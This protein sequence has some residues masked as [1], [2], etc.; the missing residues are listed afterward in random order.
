VREDFDF[1]D[2]GIARCRTG[3]GCCVAAQAQ[4]DQVLA[5]VISAFGMLLEIMNDD[6]L[7]IVEVPADAG[8]PVALLDR[9]PDHLVVDRLTLEPN[10]DAIY[11]SQAEIRR[12]SL[13]CRAT[14]RSPLMRFCAAKF[15]SNRH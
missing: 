6:P 13:A 12:P 9:P 10:S 11:I 4:N 1:G 7:S 15:K 5:G 8:G 14:G 2:R 3:C